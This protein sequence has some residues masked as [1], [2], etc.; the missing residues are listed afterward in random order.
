MRYIDFGNTDFD[1]AIL[2]KDSL[3]DRDRLVT[4]YLEPMQAAGF[5][6]SGVIAFDLD[7]GGK[8]KPT[9]STIKEYLT[10]DLL[11]EFRNLG[12]QNLLVCDGEY[13]KKIAKVQKTTSQQGLLHLYEGMNVFLGYGYGQFFFNPTLRDS[14]KLSIDALVSTS[15]GSYKVLGADILKT[16]IYPSSL[17]EIAL[18]LEAL[19][20]YPQITC[21]I[22]AFSLKHYEAGIGSISF[23][24]NQHE[25]CSFLCDYKE[26]PE[27]VNVKNAAGHK[28]PKNYYG[29]QIVNEAVRALLKTFFETYTGTIIYHNICYDGYNLAYQLWMT[30]LID[31]VGL[32]EGLKHMTRSFECTKLITYVATNTCAGNHLSLKEQAHEFTGNYAEEDIEDIRLIPAKQLLKYNLVDSCATWFVFEKNRPIMVRDQQEDIYLNRLM[33]AVRDIIQMQL[34]GMCLDMNQVDK[35]AAIL[36]AI[37]DKAL[38]TIHSTG[39]VKQFI[40]DMIDREVTERNAA[41]KKKVITAVDAKYELNLNSGPQMQ[42]L[43]YTYMSL[44]V[45][46]KTD[47]GQPSVAGDTITD[48]FHHTNDPD[49]KAILESFK[50]FLLVD[51]ILGTFIK[52]MRLAPLAPDGMHYL[53]GSFNLGGT[54]SGRLSSSNP[55]LQ[56]IPSGSTY[57]KLIKMCFVAPPGWLMVG[58]DFN[59]LEDYIS[60]LTTKDPNKIK[61]YT[62]GYDGHSL[63]AF[64]YYKNQMPDIVDTVESI[65]SI[66]QKYPQ[67][68]QDS[69]PITFALT[70]QGTWYTLYKRCGLTKGEAVRIENSFRELYTVSIDWVNDKLNQASI[71]GYVTGAF[72]LRVRTPVMKQVIM[73][74]SK[75]PSEA[76]AEGRTAG[77]ALGQS[78]GLMNTRAGTDFLNRVRRSKYVMDVR[79]MAHIHDAQYFLIRDDYELLDWINVELVDAVQWQDLPELEH[80]TVKL[81]GDLSIF[82]PHWGSEI[83]IKNGANANAI[84]E[85]VTTFFK[86]TE[87][88]AEE[89]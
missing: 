56:N 17:D 11:P 57:A 16:E 19:H 29:E 31:Q 7:Y 59:S 9:A 25:G 89:E 61:V 39:I 30:S 45:L 10:K 55:N 85:T 24:W 46:E 74:N 47:T 66:K 49:F 48:L 58:L 36:Q 20:Q 79:P 35:S 8:K 52:A 23:A 87:P 88:D 41:Y 64:T 32:I 50:D 4:E 69:K 42:E 60:A 1:T 5:D 81:G 28:T 51:K 21:D 62:D 18:S 2:V 84:R 3:M 76:E 6:T 13:F 54:V 77:N 71:D 63:R 67:F 86:P 27:P 43:L 75:T 72:G 12:I 34:T 78:Y 44:P 15:A 83:V 26:L 65:N 33:P 73:G 80:P 53:F 37:K 22:E 82:Y 40:A 14:L 38:A 70:Y 68:R